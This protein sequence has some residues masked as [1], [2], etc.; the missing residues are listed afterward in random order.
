M[1]LAVAIVVG[2]AVLVAVWF[3][4][5]GYAVRKSATNMLVEDTPGDPNVETLRYRVP[6]TQ[7]PAVLITHLEQVGYTSTL[8]EVRGDKVLSIA[9]PQGRDDDRT[10]IRSALQEIDTTGLEGTKLNPGRVT[11][12]D[13]T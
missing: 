10:R 2:I 1:G 13:E 7:D 5:S 11:F 12:E 8:D 6:D 3:V 9:C 4:V